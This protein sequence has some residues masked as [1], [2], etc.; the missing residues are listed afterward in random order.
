MKVGRHARPSGRKGVAG[1]GRGGGGGGM[2]PL[3]LR[4]VFAAHFVATQRPLEVALA[5]TPASR[6]A[7]RHLPCPR[8]SRHW[9]SVS[10]GS[11]GG[12]SGGG[13]LWEAAPPSAVC[14]RWCPLRGPRAIPRGEKFSTVF[15]HALPL[16]GGVWI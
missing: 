3:V 6:A 15:C 13:L 7:I 16:S 12:F 10:S 8:G 5:S 9:R 1:H 4:A 11:G 2:R 14:T